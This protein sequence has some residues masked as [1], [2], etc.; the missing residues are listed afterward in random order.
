ME[1]LQDESKQQ[2]NCVRTYA[3]DYANGESDIY[4]MRKVDNPEKSLVTVE[5]ERNRVVQSRIKHNK[6]PNKMQIK[7]LNKWEKEVL[8]KVA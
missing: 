4:F 3:E 7:F 6:K 8:G 5:V 2:K 1:A